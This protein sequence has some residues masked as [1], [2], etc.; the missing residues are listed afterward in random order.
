VVEG[1]GPSLGDVVELVVGYC[2]GAVNSHDAYVVVEDGV[3]VDV[4]PI[5]GRGPGRVPSR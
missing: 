2:G 4:W 3:A 1:S 5:V